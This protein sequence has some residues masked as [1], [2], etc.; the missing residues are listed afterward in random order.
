MTTMG[1]KI[2][3]QPIST[4][5]KNIIPPIDFQHI[6]CIGT[7]GAGK[8]ASLILP[9]LQDRLNKGHTIIF[10]DHK[11]H[12]HQKVKYLAKQA[13][14]LQD[15]VEIGKPHTHYINLLAEI[16][17]RIFKNMIREVASSKDPYWSNS[18]ANLAEDIIL[19]LQKL[20]QIINILKSH[21][22]E[23]DTIKNPFKTLEE[24][25]IDITQKSS[26]QTISHII[27]SPQSLVDY[28]EAI[29]Q[30]PSKLLDLIETTECYTKE[31]LHILKRIH[32]EIIH[33]EKYIKSLNR[34]NTTTTSGDSTGNNGVLQVLD[35]TIASYSKKDY[36][37]IEDYSIIDLINKN[38]I[39][40]IDTQSLDD[41]IM[42]LFF[43][44][45]LKNAVKR[46][47]NN[48]TSAMSIFIDE[49]NRVLSSS[50]DLHDDVLREAQVELILA[51]QNEEQ[52]IQK[53]S[54]IKWNS[55]KGNI[56]HKYMI[57]TNHNIYYN[58][59][60]G[61]ITKPLLIEQKYLK[62][63]DCDYYNLTTNQQNI[64]KKFLG[65]IDKL[66]DRFIVEYDIDRFEYD[67]AIIIIDDNNNKYVFNYL[68]Q[69]TLEKLEQHHLWQIKKS[70]IHTCCL[71]GY[72]EDKE[73]IE[74]NFEDRLEELALII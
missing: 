36:I 49:A 56:K 33:L 58:N 39:I 50:I 44:S 74:I 67:S 29:Q 59:N 24:I 37:N 1:F 41:D 48:T 43:E 12:E 71:S 52:M 31:K 18:A 35:N 5:N 25:N 20:H 57:D 21:N 28:K 53:F 45:I 6:L 19:T 73:C 61:I 32:G 69:E 62:N 8:T 63:T 14:R 68:G 66:P 54:H 9:T 3:Q 10:F 15:V 11:G 7:T 64:T 2:E 51:I 4:K 34:F 30:I 23:I 47:R 60:E 26:F 72:I 46:L 40:V 55:I 38:A 65:D 16:D 13:G 70:T 27:N 17:R 42:K 22:I